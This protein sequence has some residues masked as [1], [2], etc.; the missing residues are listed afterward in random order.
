LTVF[1]LA[2]LALALPGVAAA[3]PA[4]NTSFSPAAGSVVVDAPIQPT[5]AVPGI[6]SLKFGSTAGDAEID[7]PALNAAG[8]ITGL[9]ISPNVKWDSLNLTQ[10]QPLVMSG[11]AIEEA[12]IS[13][14]GVNQG[15]TTDASALIKLNPSAAF[16][17]SGKFGFRYDGLKQ[18]GGFML[19]NV[20]LA[21]GGDPVHVA[22]SGVNTL[23]A[24]IAID[25]MKV[26]IPAANTSMT[27]E[28]YRVKDG[29]ADWKA[30]TVANAP[31]TAI[32]F[33]NVGSISQMQLSVA[34]PGA[35][36]ATMG[37]ARLNVNANNAARVDGQVYVINDPNARQAGIALSKGSMA[38]Q[39][40]GGNFQMEGVNSIQGGVKVDAINLAT[41][42]LKVSVAGVN[43]AGANIALDALQVDMPAAHASMKME[44]YQ[45][46]DGRADWK[47]ISVANAPNTAIQFGNVGSISQMQLA[48]AGPGTAYA[49][50]GSAKL[51]INANNAARVNGQFY[52]INDP[53]TRQ[54]GMALGQGNLAFQ[55]AGW[56][57]QMEGINSIQ[58]GV[59]VDTVSL[60]AQP[61]SLTA[62]VTAL[63]VSNTAGVVFDQAKVSYGPSSPNASGFEMMVTRSKAGY[64]LTTTTVI[65]AVTA[66]K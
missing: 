11:A 18:S 6:F 8:A 61:L 65:P 64:V 15:Y 52:V 60:A 55:A 9:S 46:K 59:K 14:L 63:V 51:N 17:T 34:G 32:Q 35:A 39:L 28:G 53:A 3:A 57:F 29:R 44:G 13:M 22:L 1:V 50:T 54:M 30:I 4:G 62:E 21:V 25:T 49:T 37:T 7:I 36:Y 19:Q 5:F 20:A 56:N 40:S 26:N 12:R 27:V 66:S 24:G 43:A 2:L 47:A 45:V 48:V 38:F 31:N 16:Q 33:G 23:D 42:A 10:K 58:G 41:D